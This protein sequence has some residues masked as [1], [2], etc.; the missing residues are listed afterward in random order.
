MFPLQSTNNPHDYSRWTV[1]RS[2]ELCLNFGVVKLTYES[3]VKIHAV[4]FVDTDLYLNFLAQGF[5]SRD[6]IFATEI[7]TW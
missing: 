3:W 6:L 2:A 5:T 4:F 7:F 1:R